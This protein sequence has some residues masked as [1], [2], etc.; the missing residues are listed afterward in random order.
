LKR[1]R[2]DPLQ[3]DQGEPG[4]VM[5]RNEDLRETWAMRKVSA[6]HYFEGHQLINLSLAQCD[7]H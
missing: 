4:E 3:D 7:R 2:N 5:Y 1:K 6:I